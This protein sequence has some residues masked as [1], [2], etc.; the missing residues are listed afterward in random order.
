[1]APKASNNIP[2]IQALGKQKRVL[3][4]SLA[5]PD[6]I[7][8]LAIKRR[9]HAAAHAAAAQPEPTTVNE[10]HDPSPDPLN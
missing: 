7:D 9:K 6:N 1:M 5:S 8:P 10:I 2:E 4:A 3:A